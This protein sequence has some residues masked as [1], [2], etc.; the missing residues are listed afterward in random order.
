MKIFAIKSIFSIILF[1]NFFE[2]IRPINLY[3][4]Q[5]KRFELF[6]LGT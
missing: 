5:V 2:L 4:E 3:S 6:K 1:C